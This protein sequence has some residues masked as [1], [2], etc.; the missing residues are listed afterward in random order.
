MLRSPA[1]RRFAAW[2]DRGGLPDPEVTRIVL[3]TG[4]CCAQLRYEDGER[5]GSC[6]PASVWVTVEAHTPD[7]GQPDLPPG[8]LDLP[9]GPQAWERCTRPYWPPPMGLWPA[10]LP[11]HRELA[12]A[13]IQPRLA[14]V[15]RVNGNTGVLPALA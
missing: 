3:P 12:S 14:S 8:L 13:H 11:S 2:L 10:V 1:G 9:G 7:P 4:W 6:D 5:C 15:A